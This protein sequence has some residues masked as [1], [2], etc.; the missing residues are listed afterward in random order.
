MSQ[1]QGSKDVR[2][3]EP[4]RNRKESELPVTVKQEPGVQERKIMETQARARMEWGEAGSWEAGAF[5]PGAKILL[6]LYN[7]LH[8]LT[9]QYACY[10]T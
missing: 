9:V 3:W 4:G 10:G 5:E 1:E 7:V 2:I 6:L 8:N